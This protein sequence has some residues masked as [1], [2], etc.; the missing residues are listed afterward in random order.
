MH[1]KVNKLRM[2][3]DKLLCPRT[4]IYECRVSARI[5]I[6]LRAV[7]GTVNGYLAFW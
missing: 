5:R 4:L 1:R 3:R 6:E 2:W 7:V